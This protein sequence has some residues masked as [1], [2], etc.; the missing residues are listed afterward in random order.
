MFKMLVKLL[1][2]HT[3]YDNRFHLQLQLK[4]ET[5]NIYKSFYILCQ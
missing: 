5:T 4:D 2:N 1:E 3:A